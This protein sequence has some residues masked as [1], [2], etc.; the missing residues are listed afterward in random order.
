MSSVT[1]HE[2]P[3]R[4][5]RNPRGQGAQLRTDLLDALLVLLAG[6]GDPEDI[7]IRAVAKAVGVSPTAVYQHFADRDAMLDAA[8][9]RAFEHFAEMLIAATAPADGPFDRLS[10]AGLAYLHYA[11]AEPGLYRVLFSNPLHLGRHDG[12]TFPD[13]DS[14]GSTAFEVLVDMVQACLDAGAPGNPPVGQPADATYL[15]FQIWAWL[16]GIVD[17]HITHPA[18]PWPPAD[19]MVREVQRVLGLSAPG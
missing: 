3:E 6:S 19:G 14:A 7:S 1:R 8:C 5:P 4:R 2:S 17:L 16:H 11:E 9:D 12:G 18:M 10:A 13:A 15:S